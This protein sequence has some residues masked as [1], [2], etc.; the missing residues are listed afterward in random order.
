VRRRKRQADEAAATFIATC[1]ELERVGGVMSAQ[2][3]PPTGQQ[4]VAFYS[5]AVWTALM[6]LPQAWRRGDD[7]RVLG[8]NEK[9]TFTGPTAEWTSGVERNIAA[10]EQEKVDA[11]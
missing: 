10:R 5:R 3:L 7:F 4:R 9:R 11:A 8:Y 6:G 2:G 1:V